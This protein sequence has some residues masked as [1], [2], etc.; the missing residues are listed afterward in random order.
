MKYL[1][2]VLGLSI[3]GVMVTGCQTTPE[4]TAPPKP[5]ETATSAPTFTPT[6]APTSTPEPTPTPDPTPTPT[7]TPSRAE[8]YGLPDGWQFF[9]AEP[10]ED[11]TNFWTTARDGFYFGLPSDWTCHDTPADA[12]STYTCILDESPDRFENQLKTKLTVSSFWYRGGTTL[13]TLVPDYEAGEAYRGYTCEST[14]LT[15]ADLEAATV[16]CTNP[17]YDDTLDYD[18]DREAYGRARTREIP[19]YFILILNGDRFEQFHFR[20]WEKSEMPSLFEEV[21]PYIG[22]TGAE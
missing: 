15:I 2:F 21:I 19:N 14:Y 22:Y 6:E 13:T 10:P 11:E 9:P 16:A 7:S 3:I 5:T 8:T 12:G 18:T 20:T 4:P 17:A 1:M